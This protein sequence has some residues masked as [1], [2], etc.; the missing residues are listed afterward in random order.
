VE[1]P[2]TDV[3]AFQQIHPLQDWESISEIS[4]YS[5]NDGGFCTTVRL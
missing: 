3:G 4:I 2:Y 1:I 5:V